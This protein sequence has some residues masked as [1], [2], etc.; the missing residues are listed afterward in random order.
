M[1]GTS[2]E[3]RRHAR[4]PVSKA[5]KSYLCPWT[6]SYS[7]ESF[8]AVLQSLSKSRESNYHV[9]S[10]LANPKS[11]LQFHLQILQCWPSGE[12]F[13][14]TALLQSCH[15][16]SHPHSPLLIRPSFPL[17]GLQRRP[18]QPFSSFALLLLLFLSLLNRSRAHCLAHESA[19]HKVCRHFRLYSRLKNKNALRLG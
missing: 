13:D 9:G 2:V 10:P 18:S 5:W 12:F 6:W 17:L 1:A 8:H 3:Y 4:H 16:H 7:R 11:R 14:Q 19:S 15:L